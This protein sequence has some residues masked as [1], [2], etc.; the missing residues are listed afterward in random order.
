MSAAASAISRAGFGAGAY[1]GPC[2][3][4]TVPSELTWPERFTGFGAAG[5]RYQ[6]PESAEKEK[7]TVGQSRSQETRSAAAAVIGTGQDI[8]WPDYQTA[9]CRQAGGPE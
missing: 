6:N 2:G 4:G 1:R 5:A 8:R 3:V 9:A 7:R